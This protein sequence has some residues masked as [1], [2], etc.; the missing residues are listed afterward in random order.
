LKAAFPAAELVACDLDRAGV[1][2]CARALGAM[3]VYATPDPSQ[4]RLRG[5]FDLIWCGSL[6]THLDAPR[7]N[8]FL[9]FFS[10]QLSPGGVLLFTVHGRHPA[11][12]LR[13]M[14]VT[15]AGVATMLAG[16]D[17]TGF[18]YAPY[19]PGG[20]YGMAIVSSAWVREPVRR[21]GLQLVDH[22]EKAWE[23]PLPRQDVVVCLKRSVLR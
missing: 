5:E 4:L 7:W 9:D 16:H 20:D 15:E 18:G 17:A 19:E 12:A 1:D 13:G 8:G 3:P 11:H 6:F 21:S 2:F 14:D 10:G 22:A 23:P